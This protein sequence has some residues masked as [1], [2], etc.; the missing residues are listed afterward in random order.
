MKGQVVIIG[1]GMGG[2]TAAIRLARAGVCVR[3][4]EAR[5]AAGGLASGCE[6][7]GLQ[8]D[9]GPYILLDCPGLEWSF[10]ALGL[11]LKEQ[12]AL[13]RIDDVY[14]VTS[15]S[16]ERVC[17]Y[18]DLAETAAGFER[19]WPGSGKRYERFVEAVQ[20]SYT[21]LSPLLRVAHPGGLDLLRHRAL[22]QALFLLRS[23]G[24]ILARTG[25]PRPLVD[26]IG[27]WTHIAGQRLDAAPSPLAFVPALL[28][29]VGAYYPVEGIRA[30]PRLLADVAVA[31]GVDMRYGV[32]VRRIVCKGNR[33]VGV[34]TERG[35]RIAADAII[36][37]HSGIGTYLEMLE[38]TP[39][40]GR[41]QLHRLP[42]QSPGACAYLAVQGVVGSTYLRFHLPGG[43]A[44][45]R[46]LVLPSTIAPESVRDGWSPALLIAPMDHASAEQLGAAGQRAYLE[47]LLAERWWREHVAAARLLATRIPS[48][49]GA[50]YYLYRDSMNPV[51]TARFMRA[52]RLPHRSPYVRGLYLAGS[53]THPGQ[54]MSFCAISGVLS[55]NAVLEDLS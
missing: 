22:P 24:S 7:D 8:F 55:A 10:R 42:L 33:A 37:N 39:Q 15:H 40:R 48:E 16:A 30:I 11:D 51:M 47:R 6:A 3:V 20:E 34:E 13:Q 5:D 43:E 53:S 31:A 50:Q 25:L 49:W 38:E 27:I 46:L 28:H 45:C 29:T 1:S 36:S 17:F 12:I 52:G 21:K 35:E 26:A 9:A 41:A 32:A 4:L 19:R 18:A 23:L 14:E 2:L 54:W 44:F